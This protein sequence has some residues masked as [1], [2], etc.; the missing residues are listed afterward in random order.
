MYISPSKNKPSLD[1]KCVLLASP[2]N[3]SAMKLFD[4]QTNVK[5]NLEQMPLKKVTSGITMQET[6]HSSLPL[7]LTVTSGMPV[8]PSY[9]CKMA[10]EI[11]PMQVM[12]SNSP[13]LPMRKDNDA[14][15]TVFGADGLKAAR[16]KDDFNSKIDTQKQLRKWELDEKLEENA[17]I[18]PVLYANMMHKKLKD[19][20]KGNFC[21]TYV[22]C[23]N[24]Y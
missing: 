7:T 4:D 8:I 9:S 12:N 3:I 24:S 14:F 13:T 11:S 6:S 17:T 10:D 22:T 18:S 5:D 23:K 21:H 20:Y 16:E 1:D 2:N 15:E 19:E